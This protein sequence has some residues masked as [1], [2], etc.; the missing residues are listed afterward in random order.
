[1]CY[2]VLEFVL[3]DYN[4]YYFFLFFIIYNFFADIGLREISFSSFR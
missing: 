3:V 4:K 1:M 2:I